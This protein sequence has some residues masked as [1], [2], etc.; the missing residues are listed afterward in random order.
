MRVRMR[1]VV[2]SQP[3][4]Q[5]TTQTTRP[6]SSVISH[7]ISL[8]HSLATIDCF[9]TRLDK[10]WNSQDVKFDYKQNLTGLHNRSMIT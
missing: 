8:K 10:F 2:C 1:A 4:E 6:Y 5:Y 9:K 7:S 3:F